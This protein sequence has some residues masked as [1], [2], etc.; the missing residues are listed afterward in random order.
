MA[1]LFPGKKTYSIPYFTEK[2]CLK[3]KGS[4][5]WTCSPEEILLAFYS[6]IMVE[7]SSMTSNLTDFI[8]ELVKGAVH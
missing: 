8:P 7:R 4:K 2:S 6:Y 3:L 5:A 1:G